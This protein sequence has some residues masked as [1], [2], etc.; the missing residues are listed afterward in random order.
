MF[1]RHKTNQDG[2]RYYYVVKT[3]YENGRARQKTVKY[4]GAAE[5][6]LAVFEEVEKWHSRK[7]R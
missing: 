4:L 3:L 1:I 6:I 5:K 7:T 2:R